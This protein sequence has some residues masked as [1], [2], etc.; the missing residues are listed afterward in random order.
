[1]FTIVIIN[2]WLYNVCPGRCWDTL[3]V[4]TIADVWICE[5][6]DAIILIVWLTVRHY[7]ILWNTSNGQYHVA[8]CYIIIT[9]Y[10][11]SWGTF[12][13]VFSLSLSSF[14]SL[15]Y[16]YLFF[17]LTLSP[18]SFCHLSSPFFS[19]TFPLHP[20]FSRSSP[21]LPH[22]TIL[23]KLSFPLF[24]SVSFLL[25]SLSLLSIARPL[26]PNSPLSHSL[27]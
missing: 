18:L 13:I 7:I 8:L 4:W 24:I 16:H 2:Y 11:I 6:M 27:I 9:R 10:C 5:T 3:S 14:L 21:S 17:S 25:H 1:M 20:P 15:L 23:P 12:V 26:D 19:L 22:L